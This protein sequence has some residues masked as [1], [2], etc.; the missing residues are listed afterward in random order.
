MASGPGA[1][2]TKADATSSAADIAVKVREDPLFMIKKREEEAKSL[3]A[4]NPVKLRQL[5]QVGPDRPDSLS[6]SVTGYWPLFLPPQLVS[7]EKRREKH[8]KSKKAKHRH[9]KGSVRCA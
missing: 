7:K 2:F 9:S 1:L 3:L 8:K 4:S 6:L 5:Q